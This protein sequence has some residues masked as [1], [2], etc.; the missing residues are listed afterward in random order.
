MFGRHVQG[1][2]DVL[3]HSW[4]EEPAKQTSIEWMLEM[5]K[6][7]D[8]MQELTQQHHLDRQKSAKTWYDQHAKKRSFQDGEQVL[9]LMP[10]ASGKLAAQWQGPYSVL[11][12]V[13]PVTYAIDMVDR[14]K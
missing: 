5:R 8:S 4:I 12:Q 2:L 14:R 11:E 13:S 9:V 1:P 3:R 7:L 6:T 10:V